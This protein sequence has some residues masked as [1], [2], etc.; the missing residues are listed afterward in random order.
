MNI[1]KFFTISETLVFK[2]WQHQNYSVFNTL[3]RHVKIGML[4]MA[5]FTC[6]GYMNTFAQ[7]DTTSIANKIRLAEVEVTAHRAPSLYSEVGRLITVVPRSEIEALP[8]QSVQGVLKYMMNVDV[9]ERGPLGVQADLSLRGGSFDQ[10]MI[11]LNGVNITD[12]QTGHHNLNLPVDL[13]SIDRIE[14]IEG[15]A[16]RVHGPNAFSGAINI[17]TGTSKENKVSVNTLAG[18]NGL[19]NAGA[20]L[21]HNIDNT[22]SYLSVSKGGSDGYID[23][24]DFDILNLFYQ[25]RYKKSHESLNFQTGYTNKAFGANSF[26]TATF[27]NQFEQTRTFFSSL[28]FETG[29]NIRLKPNIYWRRHHD[30]FELFRDSKNAATWYSGHNYH[31]TDVFGGNINAT[32]PWSLGKTSVGGEVRS[33]NIWSNN[34]GVDMDEPLDVPGESGK[35]FTKS[36]HRSNAS[37][38]LEHNFKL[39][40][41]SVSGGIMA[42]FNSGLN[43]R[44]N[45]FPGVDLS[46]WISPRLKWMASYNQSLRMPTFT[47]LFYDGP[48]NVGNPDLEPEEASTVESGVKYVNKVISGHINGFYRNGKNLIDWGRRDGEEEYTTSNVNEINAYGIEVGTTVFPKKIGVP[49]IEKIDLNYAWLD[50]DKNPEEGYE[51]VYVLNHLEHKFNM[52]VHHDIV[53]NISARWNFLFQDR[54]GSFTRSSDNAVIEYEPFWLTDLRI[55]WHNQSWRVFA[56]AANLFDKKYYD[57]GELERPGRW[58][59]A[60][61][62]FSVSY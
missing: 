8:V 9:R 45:W 4:T 27:P 29:K 36:Y 18:E 14:I 54:V 25:L 1:K 49:V 30:R 46:Y 32:I 56:E 33:E 47:D 15:P 24:T 12:P 61:V 17:I 39:G 2:R 55:T 10:V 44:F 7:T 62:Q 48:T 53:K 38:F 35:Q 41:L 57:M 58:I 3:H 21:N 31:M 40:N 34:I 37:L 22:T 60:G 28:G 19:Y 23:N 13:N 59:K 42:N 6:L 5:Y 52:G 43:Y 26:Y 50:Q 20:T 11:L 51:S 16:S